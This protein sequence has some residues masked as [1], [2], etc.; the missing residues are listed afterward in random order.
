TSDAGQTESY[1]LACDHGHLPHRDHACVGIFCP[2]PPRFLENL[3]L[4][5]HPHCLCCFSGCTHFSAA[6]WGV[7]VRL[8]QPFRCFSTRSPQAP[9]ARSP[10]RNRSSFKHHGNIYRSRGQ[11]AQGYC[12]LSAR[13]SEEHTSE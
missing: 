10:S 6:C 2:H 8:A 5:V 3:P 9:P 12:S 1:S 13:R 4:P 11:K 7:L